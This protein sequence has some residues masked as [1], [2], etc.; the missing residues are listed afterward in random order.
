MAFDPNDLRD[1]LM[2]LHQEGLEPILQDMEAKASESAQI[3]FTYQELKDVCEFFNTF[4]Y[5]G[6]EHEGL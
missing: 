3:G 1:R 6:E 2:R 5:D 4:L